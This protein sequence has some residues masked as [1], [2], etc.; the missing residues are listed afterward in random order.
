MRTHGGSDHSR[1]GAGRAPHYNPR[2]APNP[3]ATRGRR[4]APTVAACSMHARCGARPAGASGGR[5]RHRP[6]P[7]H[8]S[9][10]RPRPVV[11]TRRLDGD[12]ARDRHGARA[13]SVS[14]WSASA[15]SRDDLARFPVVVESDGGAGAHRRR[16][17]RHRR[18]AAGD[19]PARGAAARATSPRCASPRAAS[20]SPT[21]PARSPPRCGAGRSSPPGSAASL[22]LETGIGDIDVATGAPRRR[23][24]HPLADLQRRRAPRLRRAAVRR[25]GDGAGAERHRHL[26]AA[27]DRSRPAGGRAGARRRSAAASR[28]SRST[29]SAATSRSPWRS[30]RRPGDQRRVSLRCA[31]WYRFDVGRTW[32]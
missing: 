7:S 22:R 17:E 4:S 15:P 24:S 12:G 25:P 5:R 10:C 21:S 16:A 14:R 28:W 11:E 19:D 31:S 32:A 6:R 20:T 30:G 1:P 27:A 23:R 26:A 8:D 9:R 18:P 2:H 3:A 13:T 29:S